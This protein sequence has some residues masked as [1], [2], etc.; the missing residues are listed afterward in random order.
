MSGAVGHH[1]QQNGQES[2]GASRRQG[3]LYRVLWCENTSLVPFEHENDRFAKTDSGQTWEKLRQNALSA[4][5]WF[6]WPVN[7]P[8]LPANQTA[9]AVAADTA[10]VDAVPKIISATAQLTTH[11]TLNDGTCSI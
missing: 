3:R 11:A 5:I 8:L 9:V 4:G 2:H 7:I 10:V 1:T 6:A